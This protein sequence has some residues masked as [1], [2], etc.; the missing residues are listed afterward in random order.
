MN[1][2]GTL[3]HHFVCTWIFLATLL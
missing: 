1:N 2:K 3:I